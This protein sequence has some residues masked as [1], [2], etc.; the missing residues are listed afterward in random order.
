MDSLVTIAHTNLRNQYRPFGANQT[1]SIKPADRRLHA[2]LLGKT[3][4]GKSTLLKNL[5]V[6][7]L[8]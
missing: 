4:T 2:Y 7:Y 6:A 5:V 8:R 1:I 3:G